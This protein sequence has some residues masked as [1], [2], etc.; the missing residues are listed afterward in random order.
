MSGRVGGK[1]DFVISRMRNMKWAG[2]TAGALLLLACFSPWVYIESRQ[3][4]IT[5]VDTAG[6][7]FGKPAFLHF[8]L[9]PAFVLFTIIPRIWAK[10]WNLLIGAV[11]L[12]WA[13]RNYLETTG[14]SGGE[15]PEKK[16]GTIPAAG[17]GDPHAVIHFFP[18]H[19]KDKNGICARA[20]I[21]IRNGLKKMLG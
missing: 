4:L 13:V 19:A 7:N 12:A 18:R 1:P 11:N 17:R 9:L 20:A 14:C 10:R 3:W 15:C 16:M 8:V 2:L 6:T 5:G 21:Y